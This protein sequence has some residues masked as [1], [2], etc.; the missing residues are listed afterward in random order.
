M[1][2]KR[3]NNK[4]N[5]RGKR[6]KIPIVEHNRQEKLQDELRNLGSQIWLLAEERGPPLEN[7]S[8]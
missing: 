5:N 7:V 4:P 2:I 8:I 6:C 3:L 1:R